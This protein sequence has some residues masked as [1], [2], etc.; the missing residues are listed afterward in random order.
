LAAEAASLVLQ[1]A[2]NDEDSMPQ[3]PV[4]FYPQETFTERDET[5]NVKNCVGI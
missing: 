1:R 3:C 5:R 4:G 2:P